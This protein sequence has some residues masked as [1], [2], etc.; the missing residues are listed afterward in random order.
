LGWIFGTYLE[1]KLD[2]KILRTTHRIG[3]LVPFLC[4]TKTKTEFKM[5]E[6][7]NYWKTRLELKVN[8]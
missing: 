4:E 1:P 8:M 5:F 6:K 2:L 3:F 7:T